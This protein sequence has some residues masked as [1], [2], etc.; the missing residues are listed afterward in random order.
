[1]SRQITIHTDC[2]RDEITFKLGY[3]W[4]E[5]KRPMD[6]VIVVVDDPANLPP[7]LVSLAKPQSGVPVR[8][9]ICHGVTGVLDK[10]REM[11]NQYRGPEIP[12]IH[13]VY[14][15][16]QTIKADGFMGQGALPISIGSDSVLM[17]IGSPEIDKVT[18]FLEKV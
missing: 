12:Q 2:T 15:L 14:W 4:G 18:I 7:L 16:P 9:A 6:H 17:Q 5:A 3:K 13:A 1:M 11:R 10:A 8:L